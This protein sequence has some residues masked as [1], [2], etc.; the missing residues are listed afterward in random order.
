M[1]CHG[2]FFL[3]ET[4]RRKWYNPEA[5]LESVGLRSG[6]FFMDVG[7]GDGFFTFLAAQAVGETGKVYAVM[8]T[9]QPLKG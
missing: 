9:L 3:E 5:L 8:W 2:G 4:V 7:C 6:M 1:S